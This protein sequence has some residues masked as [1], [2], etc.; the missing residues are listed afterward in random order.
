MRSERIVLALEVIV[1]AWSRRKRAAALVARESR[2]TFF[3]IML[4]FRSFS[5]FQAPC[6]SMRTEFEGRLPAGPGCRLR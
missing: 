5:S 6:C 4:F 3:W 1:R 2:G